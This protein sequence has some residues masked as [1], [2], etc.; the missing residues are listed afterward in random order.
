MRSRHAVF[1]A[2]A[3]LVA[4]VALAWFAAS[5]ADTHEGE[6]ARDVD[7]VHDAATTR[8]THVELEA[9]VK[10]PVEAA[11]P[12]VEAARVAYSA[13]SP[14]AR[15]AIVLGALSAR[16]GSPVL[17]RSVHLDFWREKA[18]VAGL[19][20]E[21]MGVYRA[22]PFAPGTYRVKVS[23]E[24]FDALEFQLVVPD[25]ATTLVRDLVLTEPFVL[26][27]HAQTD[28]KSVV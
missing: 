15:G 3:V 2:C 14:L 19:D 1:V 23:S 27:V 22:G 4:I 6:L 13:D 21:T 28:R 17:A 12:V 5:G 26:V 18:H 8:E 9:S 10:A 24:R 20:N 16:D 7:V 25:D 11:K